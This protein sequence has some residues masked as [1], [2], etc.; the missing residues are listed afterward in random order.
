MGMEAPLNLTLIVMVEFELGS[1]APSMAEPDSIFTVS[2][3]L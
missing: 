1:L 3:E 2:C